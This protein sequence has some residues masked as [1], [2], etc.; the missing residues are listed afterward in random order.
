MCALGIQQW[1]TKQQKEYWLP[2]LA[3][4]EKI[5]AFA[6][7]EPDAGSDAN[8]VTTTAVLE[9]DYYII[10]GTKK[11]ITMSQIADVFLLEA[12]CENKVTAFLVDRHSQGLE[13][14]PITHIMRHR[15]AMIG[16]VTFTN[17]KIPKENLYAESGL[18]FHISV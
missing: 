12:K 3:S 13:V 5:G 4:G 14:E 11:W 9:G 18:E 2:K 1:G 16:K 15:S 7:T 8:S 17:C 10:N 6:L